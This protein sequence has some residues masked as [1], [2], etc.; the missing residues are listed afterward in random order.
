MGQLCRERFGENNV[1][2]IGYLGYSG[3]VTAAHEWDQ[4]PVKMKVNPALPGSVEDLFHESFPFSCAFTLFKTIQEKRKKVIHPSLSQYLATP[5]L[6]RF[7]GVVYKPATERW[8]HYSSVSLS[9]QFDAVVFMDQTRALCPLSE[10]KG[11]RKEE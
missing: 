7:I 11:I 10:V 1:Y 8:S 9:E 4:P 3:S 2:N 5:R 6:E